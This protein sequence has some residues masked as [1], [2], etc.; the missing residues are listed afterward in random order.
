MCVGRAVEEG[1]KKKKM[2]KK[3]KERR[4]ENWEDEEMR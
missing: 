4:L 3:K 2:M 1:N